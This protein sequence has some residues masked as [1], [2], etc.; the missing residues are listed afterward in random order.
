MT[1]KNE[2]LKILEE[3]RGRVLS[4]QTIGNM[5]KISRNS[6]WK[7]VKSLQKEGFS[8]LSQGNS[9][10]YLPNNSN[11]LTKEGIEVNLPESYSSIPIFVFEET[12]STNEVAKRLIAENISS[13]VVVAANSQTN[14]KG[15]LGRK[16][17]SPANSGIYMSI[18]FKPHIPLSKNFLMTTAAAV[19][20][21]RAIESITNCEAKIK[22]VND[23]FCGGK[24]ACGILAEGIS[25]LET[26]ELE[27]GIIGI[28]INCFDPEAGF[29]AE[30]KETACAISQN[31][32]GS[33]NRNLL[34]A[35]IVEEYFNIWSNLDS[36]NFMDEYKS[37]SLILTKKIN[38]I[39][40]PMA[41]SELLPATAL[42]INDDGSLLVE[43]EDGRREN[44]IVGEISLKL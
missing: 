2:V 17:F 25:T 35:R 7:A 23:I 20:V 32:I 15:R 11:S 24:K 42:A 22:W 19:A 9:G 27:W 37:R 16:F 44:L 5:L 18:A 40:N 30:I 8:I 1:T 31:S 34:I 4:G 29:P 39:K 12:D 13:P 6:V 14:G 33:F 10:Y 38:V 41:Q 28:G 3:N 43:Y 36:S 21:C 26:G